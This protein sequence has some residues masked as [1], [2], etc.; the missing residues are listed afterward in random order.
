MKNPN[1]FV[2]LITA[3]VYSGGIMIPYPHIEPEIVRVGPFAV[4][5][6]GL[7]YRI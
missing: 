5:W 4:R 2:E 3:V 7:M 6:Y 1:G